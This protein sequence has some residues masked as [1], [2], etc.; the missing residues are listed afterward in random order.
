MQFQLS[1]QDHRFI[2][3]HPAKQSPSHYPNQCYFSVSGTFGNEFQSNWSKTQYSSYIYKKLNWKSLLQYG[4]LIG[5]LL[6]YRGRGKIAIIFAD[7]VFLCI[8]L[9][10]NFWNANKMSLKYVPRYTIDNK[11][12]L[13]EIMGCHRKEDNPLYEPMIIWF[14]DAYMRNSA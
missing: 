5:S 11:P 9:N 14:T 4:A 3:W 6:T 13:V 10:E 2:Y 12:P 1:V 8:F 7:D